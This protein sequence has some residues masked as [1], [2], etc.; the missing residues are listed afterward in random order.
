V[1]QAIGV[2][3]VR[4]NA[5]VH[6]DLD[7]SYHLRPEMAV[8]YDPTLVMGVSARPLTSWPS[9]RRHIRMSLVTF[10]VEFKEEPPLRRRLERARAR[11]S[12]EAQRRRAGTDNGG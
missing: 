11:R 12:L 1:W 9:F 6:D 5:E 4:N 8:I 3:V 2:S 10:R 7:I